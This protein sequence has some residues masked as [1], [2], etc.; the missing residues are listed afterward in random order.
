MKIRIAIMA[1]L[2][3]CGMGCAAQTPFE[4]ALAYDTVLAKSTR[5][6]GSNRRLHYREEV[7]VN[8]QK[9]TQ[10]VYLYTKGKHLALKAFVIRDNQPDSLVAY[11]E[12]LVTNRRLRHVYAH[13]FAR[14]FRYKKYSRYEYRGHAEQPSTALP[15]AEPDWVVTAIQLEAGKRG[16]KAM[17]HHM[18]PTGY[19]AEDAAIIRKINVDFDALHKAIT[20]YAQSIGLPLTP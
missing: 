4:R 16:L 18:N 2:L 1:L 20:E 10:V 12:Q 15:A 5:E 11:A 7:V 19:E 8:G 14:V 17:Y 13:Y 9:Q 3:C 6:K